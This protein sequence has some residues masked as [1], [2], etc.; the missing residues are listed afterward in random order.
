MFHG[1]RR[2]RSGVTE[3][4]LNNGAAARRP[5]RMSQ[6]GSDTPV[7]CVI[8][9]L[10]ASDTCNLSGIFEFKASPLSHWVLSL[11]LSARM[12][13]LMD[14]SRKGLGPLLEMTPILFLNSC[15]LTRKALLQ[16]SGWQRCRHPG[17]YFLHEA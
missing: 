6:P 15:A 8:A 9:G 2:L 17:I 11:L 4:E 16:L 1:A 5:R 13:F 10:G 12:D 14:F 7:R 3:V